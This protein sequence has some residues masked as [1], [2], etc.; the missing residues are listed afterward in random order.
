MLKTT[1]K[2]RKTIKNNDVRIKGITLVTSE[3]ATQIMST[4][5]KMTNPRNNRW[6]FDSILVGYI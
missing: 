4:S 6:D 3:E 1:N 2:I 5:N